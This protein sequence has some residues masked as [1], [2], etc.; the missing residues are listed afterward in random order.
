MKWFD[1]SLGMLRPDY[2]GA[3]L[4][5][6]PSTAL[7]MLGVD[8]GRPK[9]PRGVFGEVTTEG[10]ENVVLF[11]FDGFGYKRW[12]RGK[13]GFVGALNAAGNLAPITT[14]FPST[15]AAALTSVVTSLTPQ[16]HCLPEWFVY[17]KEIDSIIESLPF[18]P[19]GGR[20]RDLSGPVSPRVLFEG[21]TIFSTLKKAGIHSYSYLPGRIAFSAYSSVSHRGSEIRPYITSSD[22]AISLRKGLEAAR[23]PS[24]FYVYWSS[25]D[26][27]E[28]EFGATSEEAAV[29][30][31]SVSFTLKKGLLDRLDNKTAAKTLLMA[32]ADHGQLDVDPERTMFLNR[33]RRLS[34]S[35][36]KSPAGKSILPSGGA[37]DVFLHIEPNRLDDVELYLAKKL[38]GFAS[39]VRSEAA[40]RE[41]LFGLNRPRRRFTE[42]IGNLII[43]PHRN[44]TA[45]Y[46]FREGRGFDLKGHHGGLTSDEMMIPFASARLD[47]LLGSARR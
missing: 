16:E 40:I 38:E 23:S 31:E 47:S 18:S 15:T 25:V 28:H 1:E 9:L 46:R 10:A 35:Y 32:T 8:T 30:A 7:S 39:V 11:L 5:S 3:C 4:S 2:G 27:L 29:E 44:E 34:G 43:L 22:L 41:G 20:G 13:G 17:L 21:T 26:T 12:S 42:R 45:W 19:I 36:A 33:L 6:V 14:I 37:R 24:F